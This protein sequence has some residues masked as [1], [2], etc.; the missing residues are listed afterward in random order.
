MIAFYEREGSS[1]V[2]Y[3]GSTFTFSAFL[4]GFVNAETDDEDSI[5]A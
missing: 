1:A 5:I 3:D 2:F 4:T